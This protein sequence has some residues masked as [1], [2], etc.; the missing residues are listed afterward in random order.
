MLWYV[1]GAAVA[2]V[3]IFLA[4]IVLRAVQF[5]PKP[6]LMPSAKE[7]TLEEEKIVKDMQE[8]IRCRTVSYNDASQIDEAEF[9][10]FRKLL[11]ELYPRIHEICE[12]TFLGVNGILYCWKGRE[13]GDPV[14]LMSHY[15]V[16]PVE[17]SQWEKPAFE[18]ICEGGELWGR[19]TLDTKGTLC[20]ILEAAEKLIGDGFVPKHDI[21]FAFSGQEE[22]NGST[23]PS[24]VDWF[25]EQ[26][27]HPA[28]VVDEGG[29]V[30]DNV[31]PGVDRECA[32]IGIAEKGLTNIE[33]HAKSSGGHASM[34][35]VHTIVGELAQAVVDVEKHP[36]P[37]QLTKPVR[38]MLDTLGRHSTF[39]YKLLFANLWC[40]E[41][42]FDKVC[43]KSGGE[44]NA[45]LRTTCAMTKME[46]GKAFNVIPPKA[47]VG[48]NLRLIGKDTVESAR[49]Y[50]EQVIHNPNIE[51]TVF[52][53][54][55]PSKDSDTACPEW[56]LLCQAVADT[57]KEAL[58]AP[59]LMMACSDSW[60]Y[61]R[62]TDRVYKFSAMKLSKE[63]RGMIHGNNERV[64]VKTLVKTVEFY[65]R[66]MEKC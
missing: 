10:K 63:E 4:V 8:M 39:A 43:Q 41:G 5:R 53:G 2:A 29:A 3:V 27:I 32:L 50:L 45:M 18:G 12:Q 38:E 60:H 46:G 22:I 28:M 58:V 26:G 30:V 37:R 55:N 34:P 21:Y 51:V 20:G 66:L 65:V 7:V 35:P 15:D 19:G 36:F 24:M 31:F 33:F 16:V 14:V 40:F 11:P 52:E 59:Y 9:E 64:P 54:R 47:S 61:C 44:L 48:M 49:A 17:E 56:G 1:L 13:A 25:E 23:C 62:I 42:L 6:E 57:W